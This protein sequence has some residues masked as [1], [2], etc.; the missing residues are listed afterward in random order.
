MFEKFNVKAVHIAIQS[1]LSL[2]SSGRNTGLLLDI[3]DGVTHIVPI[4]DGYALTN[5]IQ[6]I[7]QACKSILYF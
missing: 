3:G 4:T 5:A 1:C 2:Y 7:F 6:S